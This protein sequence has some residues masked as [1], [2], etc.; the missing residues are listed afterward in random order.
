MKSFKQ[1]LLE[2][3]NVTVRN[4]YG[5]IIAQAEKIDLEK[6]NL[7]DFRQVILDMFSSLNKK[8]KLWPDFS[9][10]ES[11][12]VF[13]GS[14]EFLMN[15]TVKENELSSVKSKF[16]DLDVT[17]PKQAMTKLFRHLN[18]NKQSYFTKDI[19]YIDQN[20]TELR[21][22]NINGIFFW[23][24]ENLYFQIDF[25]GVDYEKGK[26]TE[27]GKFSH[28]SSWTDIQEGIKGVAH[29]WL[30]IHL[31]SKMTK[32]PDVVL[33]TDK[34]PKTKDK[35][36]IS[37]AQDAID[38]AEFSFS[39]DHG[40]RRR[41]KPVKDFEVDGKKVYEKIPTEKSEYVTDLKKIFEF[42]FGQTPTSEDLENFKS[43]T[44]LISLI[45]KFD[46]SSELI[47][48]VFES[49]IDN[50]MFGEYAQQ[51]ERDDA[52]LDKET[53]MKIVDKMV[54]EFSYLK[55]IKISAADT[56]EKFYETYGK[57]DSK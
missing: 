40:L 39:V 37:E 16:G 3:G 23:E 25:E 17:V 47:K 53:K 33:L 56:I 8:L 49:M 48:D 24:A 2:G 19:K 36:K 13:N 42:V 4:K 21:K 51:M 10:V 57:K 55:P 30:L 22:T 6:I 54:E 1:F 46:I 45:K 11:G 15:P 32:R 14:S 43:F 28:S 27:F 5:E 20:Q 41:I 31:V 34:S 50:T 44:G 52:E 35:L 38:P 26:P 29:K 7:E 18:K 9:Q 12:F